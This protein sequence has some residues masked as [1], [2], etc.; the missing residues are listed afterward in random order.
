MQG[1]DPEDVRVLDAGHQL[2]LDVEHRPVIGALRVGAQPLQNDE[3]LEVF[4]GDQDPRGLFGAVV[5]VL[6]DV[7]DCVAAFALDLHVPVPEWTGH[8]TVQV[9]ISLG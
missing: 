5:E 6:A 7:E 3:L 4:F 1:V 2:R 8:Y 9:A